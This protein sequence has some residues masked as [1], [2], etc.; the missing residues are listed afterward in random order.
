VIAHLK[1]IL[2]IQP[3]VIAHDLHPDYFSTRWARA[4]AGLP[5]IG[6][7]HHHAHVAACMAENHLEGRVIGFALDGTGYGTDGH[8]WGGEVVLAD[9][10]TFDRAAHFNYVPMPGGAAA[11]REPWRM[12]VS[13]LFH[14]FGRGFLRFPLPLLRRHAER[15][16]EALLHMVESR[17][18]SPLTSSCGRLFDAVAAL[19]GVREQVNYEGQAAI[20]LEM[21]MEGPADSS[22]YPLALREKSVTW[23][24]GT[25]PLFEA[26]LR[27]LR[28]GL[29]PAVISRRFHNGL[30]QCFVQIALLL[31]ERSALNRV[32]LSGGTFQNTYLSEFLETQLLAEG[33]E[34]FTHSEV[35]AN[36]GGLSLGQ[37]LVAAYNSD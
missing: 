28:L 4:Q 5:L 24:I 19:L 27:D 11:I 21:A 13:Y 32:C 22:A 37:A 1:R 17:I 10:H 29:S 3:R 9:Y 33:F 12:A 34:V 36:D 18:N 30:V 7:Q 14:H 6:V 20:E 23:E 15:E 26:I 35:P 31:R 16:I 25:W 8:I 2:E